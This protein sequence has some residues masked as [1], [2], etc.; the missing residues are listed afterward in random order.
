MLRDDLRPAGA[1]P[2]PGTDLGTALS[3]ARRGRGRRWLVVALLVL[4]GGVGATL[5]ARGE[6]AGQ[7]AAIEYI[8]AE[9]TRGG[10]TVRVTATGTLE[11]VTQVEVGSEVSGLVEEVS[12]D[13]NDAVTQGQVLA[14]LDTDRLQALTVQARGTLAAAEG[15]LREMEATV[16]ET[17]LRQSR[18]EK[19]AARQMCSTDE[20]DGTRAASARAEAAV[21]SARAQVAVARATLE[22]RETD[23]GKAQIRSPI[24][25]IVLR[26]QV[27]P[28][29]TVAASLQTPV[30]FTLA[31]NLTQMELRVSVDEADIGVVHEG[32]RAAFTVDAYPGRQ[33]EARVR[34][35]RYAPETVDGVVTYKTILVV[36]ND[37]LALR[38][39]MTATAEIVVQEIADAV[40]VPNAALRFS[41]PAAAT[42]DADGGLLS[43]L[44]MRWPR[45]SGQVRPEVA[46]GAARKVWV[47]D[48]ATPRPVEITIGVTDEQHTVV[49]G[50]ELAAGARVAVDYVQPR[51]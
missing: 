47:L 16:I 27:E 43:R 5:L 42:T 6:R 25:G 34:Q 45:R 23:L 50:G 28:G 49:T 46:T 39:G 48:G 1:T 38:P 12:V 13:F 14:R 2:A 17:R 22:E 32:Q 26:R 15:R 21:A 24:D 8:G 7:Q 37:D 3:D 19:L 41:P 11:P 20:L 31:E 40:L 36:S 10:L 30:L 29:Q 9:V 44:L 18:C 4:T 35:V 51:G 33:F